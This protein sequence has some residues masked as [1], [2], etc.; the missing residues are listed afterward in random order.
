VI[1]PE[2]LGPLAERFSLAPIGPYWHRAR[3]W[4]VERSLREQILLGA[5]AAVGAFALLLVG[6]VAPLQDIRAQARA[7]IRN[8]ELLEARLRAGG[9]LGNAG[10]VRRGSA[11]AIITDS[12]AAASLT[13]QRIEPEGGFTRVVLADAPFEQVMKWVLDIEQTSRLR[14]READF[15][16]KPSP[17]QVSAS[18]VVEG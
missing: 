7:D 5:L 14:V 6:V 17:G 1:L 8:A 18:L 2:R 12:A 9:E 15:E 10:R 4:W 3:A 13:I 16:R 11:S